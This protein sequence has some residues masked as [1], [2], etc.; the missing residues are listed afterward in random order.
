LTRRQKRLKRKRLVAKKATVAIIERQ[1]L[2][3]MVYKKLVFFSS[4][5]YVYFERVGDLTSITRSLVEGESHGS[6]QKAQGIGVRAV[7][8]PQKLSIFFGGSVSTRSYNLS[9]GM[10]V[11]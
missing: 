3:S 5:F 6:F 9:N 11:C 10:V 4:Y 1:S 8:G 2:L 7:E